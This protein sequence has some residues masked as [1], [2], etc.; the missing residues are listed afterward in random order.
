MLETFNVSRVG[1]G[2]GVGYFHGVGRFRVWRWG[3]WG[4]SPTPLEIL[5]FWEEQRWSDPPSPGV[6][7]AGAPFALGPGAG[8]APDPEA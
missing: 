4:D 6:Q 7:R 8:T 5:R 2:M 3:V 1:E